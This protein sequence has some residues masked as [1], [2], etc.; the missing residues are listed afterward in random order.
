MIAAQLTPVSALK[1]WVPMQDIFIT[2]T[3]TRKKYCL[4][5]FLDGGYFISKVY[6][7]HCASLCK[8]S[9]QTDKYY[10]NE[11]KNCKTNKV[12]FEKSFLKVAL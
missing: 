10:R 12:L 1:D 2:Y 11:I 8:V 9:A 3:L 7:G 5:A 6:H 4:L